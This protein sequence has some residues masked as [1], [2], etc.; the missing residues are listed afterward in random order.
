MKKQSD[1]YEEARLQDH[2]WKLHK[3][4]GNGFSSNKDLSVFL[5]SN[6]SGEDDETQENLFSPVYLW[7]E[8]DL[9]F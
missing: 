4:L 1:G 6:P 8:E 2:Q 3:V 9:K 7:D 5:Q